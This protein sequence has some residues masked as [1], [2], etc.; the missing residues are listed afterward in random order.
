LPCSPFKRLLLAN[1]FDATLFCDC[2]Q[3][4]LREIYSRAESV[5]QLRFLI[6]DFALSATS[7][8][9]RRRRRDRL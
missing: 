9:L 5:A 1:G 7:S 4:Q 8:W 3:P 6:T 2:P